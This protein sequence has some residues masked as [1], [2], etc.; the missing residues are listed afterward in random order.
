[1][2]LVLPRAG[3]RVPRSS[4]L[5]PKSNKLLDVGCS[6]GL[7]KFFIQNRVK[8]IYGIDNDK[9]ALI[10]A[11]RK[12]LI[13]RKVNLEKDIIPYPSNYFDV[14]TCL[15]VVE[16]IRDPDLLIKKIYKVTKKNGLLIISTPN[17]RFTDHLI[18]LIVKGTFPKTSMDKGFNDEGHVHFF[19]YSDL[20]NLL[21]RNRFKVTGVHGIINK[22]ERGWKGKVFEFLFGKKWMLEFRTPGILLEAIKK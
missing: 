16:H 1:M 5:V 14:V 4:E 2:K 10:K 11:K 20:I 19:T 21:K 7:I 9:K 13:V 6:N 18:K 8:K 22:I 15:D 17:I 12:G 3:E